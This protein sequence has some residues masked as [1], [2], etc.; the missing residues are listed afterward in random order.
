M[1]V[2]IAGVPRELLWEVAL[3]ISHI[4]HAN[5]AAREPTEDSIWWLEKE[6]NVNGVSEHRLEAEPRSRRRMGKIGAELIVKAAIC[7]AL[8]ALIAGMAAA[9]FGS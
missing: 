4:A 2:T 3:A 7:A 9:F 8:I 5:A 6:P 1:E